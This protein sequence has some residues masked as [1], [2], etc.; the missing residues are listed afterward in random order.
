M[1][2]DTPAPAELPQSAAEPPVPAAVPPSAAPPKRKVLG[3]LVLMG[4]AVTAAGGAWL[5]QQQ[6]DIATHLQPPPPSVE[7]APLAAMEAPLDT[8]QQR[9]AQLELRPAPS[10]TAAA[11]DLTA[12][13]TR[14]DQVTAKV[15]ALQGS[16]PGVVQSLAGKVQALEQGLAQ[17]E[18]HEQTAARLARLQA[19]GVALAA[20]QALGDIPGAPPALATFATAAP[21]TE[22]SLRSSFSAVAAAAEQ[23]SVPSTAGLS[24]PTRMWQ[25]VESLVTVQQG[26]KVLVGPPASHVL[27]QARARLDDGDLAG[28]VGALDQ[29]DPAAAKVLA[30]WRAQAQSLL[31]ARAALAGMVRS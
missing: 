9:L 5:F 10:P 30:G 17:T 13:E 24:L 18:Q 20:G 26:G 7:P 8:L 27:A 6:R 15:T 31:D 23:A 2:E 29:L 3:A 16:D 25:Q 4:F 12:V 1:T 19:A 14:L 21:P 22:G 28:A 11:P